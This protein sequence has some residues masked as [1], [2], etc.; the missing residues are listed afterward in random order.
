MKAKNLKLNYLLPKKRIDRPNTQNIWGFDIE[1]D[2]LNKNVFLLAVITNDTETFYFQSQDELLD[3]CCSYRPFRS[4]IFVAT[5]LAYDFLGSFFRNFDRTMITERDGV[6]YGAKMKTY[7]GHTIEF[8]DTLRYHRIGVKKIGKQIGKEKLVDQRSKL[9]EKGDEVF[10]DG[11]KVYQYGKPTT[12]EQWNELKEYCQTDAYISYWFY[13]HVITK[14]CDEIGIEVKL[15]M[16]SIAMEDFR[17]NYLEYP[18]KV[19]PHEINMLVFQSYYGGHTEAYERGI[20]SDVDIFD[21]NSL[22]PATMAQ[23]WFPAPSS[24]RVSSSISIED[25]HAFEGCCYIE[26][27]LESCKYPCL[28]VRKDG[29]LLFPCGL[30]KGWYVFPEIRYALDCGFRIDMIGQGIIYEKRCKPFEKFVHDHYARR[31]EM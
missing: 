19:H 11:D 23:N 4:A 17:T 10:S 29:K 28:P 12:Q 9:N 3:F 5:N 18:T 16:S 2:P 26:G 21:V 13:K 1:T 24:Y 20:I 15:T 6:F 14:W 7:S 8:R 27:Y 30:I 22:Y 25:I 31:K